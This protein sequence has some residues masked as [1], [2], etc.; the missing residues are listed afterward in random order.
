MRILVTGACG[1]QASHLCDKYVKEGHT[2]LAL[3]NFLAGTLD[4]VKH[5]LDYNNFKLI[6]GDVRDKELLTH[7]IDGVDIIFHLAAQVH[8]DRS[9][10]EPELT[11]SI[12]VTGI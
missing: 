7:L 2:V 9:M 8:V 5:L 12:N 6:T 10:I 3:D 4:N 1:F 11:W